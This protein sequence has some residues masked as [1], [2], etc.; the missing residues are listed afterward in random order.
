MSV[1]IAS[2]IRKRWPVSFPKRLCVLVDS[3]NNLGELHHDFGDSHFVLVCL[4]NFTKSEDVGGSMGKSFRFVRACVRA[5]WLLTGIGLQ[6]WV[7]VFS[8]LPLCGADLSLL[9]FGGDELSLFPSS[10][11]PKQSSDPTLVGLIGIDTV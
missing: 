11:P 1:S 7:H 4:G 3:R 8:L 10:H 5:V 9:P 6:H 2:Q